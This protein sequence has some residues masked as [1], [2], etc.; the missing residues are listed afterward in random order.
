M[1]KTGSRLYVANSAGNSVSVINTATNAVVGGPIA[2]GGQPTGIVVSPDGSR[3]YVSNSTSNTVTVINPTAA[4]PVVATVAVG[5]QPRGL[6]ISPDGSVVYAAN[7]N[8]TVSMIN[9]K[10]T[11][12]ITAPLID[13][14]PE[15]GQHGIAVSP[16]G[17]QI[18]VS[19]SADRAVRILTINR[20]NTAP[21]RAE[22]PD[23]RHA[24]SDHRCGER[25]IDLHGHR[26]GFRVSQLGTTRQRHRQRWRC[27]CLHLHTE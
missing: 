1:A 6:A 15:T 14:A 2:V 17:R 3:V 25:D 18:Y 5:P 10:T 16:D 24:G 26:R 9:T 23:C 13:S 11:T 21:Q 19:D 22:H 7:S 27:W 20:G 4:T 12:M 8:D